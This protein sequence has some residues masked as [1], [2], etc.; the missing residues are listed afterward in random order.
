[1]KRCI[2][3]FP[4]KIREERVSGSSVRPFEM[5]N[6]FRNIGYEVHLISGYSEERKLQV[7]KLKEL[8]KSGKKFDFM[9]SESSTMPTL[10]TDKHHFPL[11]P[12]LDFGLFK[13]CRQNGIKIGLFYRDI[14]WKYPSYEKKVGILRSTVAKIFY[15]HDLRQY[16]K[17][18]NVLFLSSERVLSR[19]PMFSD[20]STIEYLPPGANSPSLKYLESKDNKKITIFY[21]GGISGH[22]EIT[23]LL[24]TANRLKNVRVIICCRKDEWETNKHLFESKLTDSVIIIHKSGEELVEYYQKSDIFSCYFKNNEYMDLAVPVKLFQYLSYKKPIIASKDTAAGDFVSENNIG[25]AI[26]Y[27]SGEIDDVLER[28]LNNRQYLLSFKNNL[29]SAHKNNTWESRAVRVSELLKS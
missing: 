15:K 23:D 21:V 28:V 11:H 29:D 16:K 24:D 8:L 10:L 19:F 27:G 26:K 1:M 14:Y 9:Y 22:Y 2:V 4:F 5:I 20:I 25:W 17:Y 12:F 6:A 3:H 13:L 7:I 18:L